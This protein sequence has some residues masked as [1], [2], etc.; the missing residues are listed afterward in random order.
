MAFRPLYGAVGSWIILMGL[1]LAFFLVA[2]D[3]ITG[4]SIGVFIDDR[5]KVSLSRFQMVAWTVLIMS[6]IGVIFTWRA[7]TDPATS[8]AITLDPQLL[9]LMG[10]STT[11]LVGSPFIKKRQGGVTLAQ[12]NSQAE[13]PKGELV[14]NDDFAHASWADM[15]MGEKIDDHTILDLGKVQMFLFTVLLLVTYAYAVYGLLG[16]ATA[17]NTLPDVGDM[18]VALLGISHGGYLINKAIPPAQK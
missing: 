12:I 16:K 8:T 15:F 1:I 2:A 11:S 13:T 9:A 3:G 10:I 7:T 6:A 17:P 4:R 14:H 5:N 18:M